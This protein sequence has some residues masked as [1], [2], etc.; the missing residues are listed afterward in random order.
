V[1]REPSLE[2]FMVIVRN[3]TFC[4]GSIT[5]DKTQDVLEVSLHPRASDDN[6]TKNC[7]HKV[8]KHEHFC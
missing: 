6:Q 1:A 4:L 2:M 5:S 8:L 3:I 7:I